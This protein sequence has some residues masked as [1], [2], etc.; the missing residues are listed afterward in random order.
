MGEYK[1]VIL[2]KNRG[3]C[4]NLDIVGLKVLKTTL[5]ISECLV[6]EIKYLFKKLSK[7]SQLEIL[8]KPAR[9]INYVF[10]VDGTLTPSR[11]RMDGEFLSFR[12]WIKIKMFIC[13]LTDHD[14]TIEQV[15]VDI[16]RSNRISINVVE[17]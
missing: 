3:T 12:D 5:L 6:N 8:D 2:Y 11:L 17:M 10:D 16:W 15:G 7:Q 13:L 9:R 4:T 1:S 14:K